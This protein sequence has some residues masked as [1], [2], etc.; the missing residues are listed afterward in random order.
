MF[1]KATKKI[2]EKSEKMLRKYLVLDANSVACIVLGQPKVPEK[3]A[4]FKKK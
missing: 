1:K 3:L 4:R 2:A